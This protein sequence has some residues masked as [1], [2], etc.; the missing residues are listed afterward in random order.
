MRGALILLVSTQ[1][2]I[3]TLAQADVI[4][5]E[6]AVCRDL[7]EGDDCTVTE[8]SVTPLDGTC[9]MDEECR[10]DYSNRCD[11]GAPCGSTC[12][13]ALKCI[14]SKTDDEDSG[15][16]AVPSGSVPLSSGIFFLMGLLLILRLRRS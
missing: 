15:S 3:P 16:C 12:S 11:S 5:P 9:Q 1:L 8:G 4:L 13:N 10:L 2:L 6:F 7:N 14:A